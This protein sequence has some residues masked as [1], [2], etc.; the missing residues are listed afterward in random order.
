MNTF[1]IDSAKQ[2]HGLRFARRSHAAKINNAE[3]FG[4]ARELA[5]LAASWPA[6]R[7][8]EVWNSFAGVAPFDQTEAG[9]EIH[10]PQGGGGADLGGG[11]A[12]LPK[13]AQQAAHVAPAKGKRKKDPHQG[14]RRHTPRPAAKNTAPR[15]RGQQEGRSDR[16]DAPLP[17]CHAG[18]DHGTDGLAAPYRSRLRQRDADQEAG[19]ESRVFPLRTKR[20]VRYRV[21]NRPSTIALSSRRRVCPWRPFCC[22]PSMF[23]SSGV[24]VPLTT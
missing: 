19:L 3:S 13:V 7:P 11:P 10:Q 9:E 17:G 23:D 16:S 22:V 12:L 20:S 1:T 15:P 4:S 21:S 14:K 18:R 5:K 6:N 2:H 24:K 8:V